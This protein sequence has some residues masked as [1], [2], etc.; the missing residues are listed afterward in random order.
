M[1]KERKL[2]HDHK[3]YT[4]T[5]RGKVV[6][7]MLTDSSL[8]EA[9]QKANPGA[10]TLIVNTIETLEKSVRVTYKGKT[11]GKKQNGKDYFPHNGANTLVVYS[12]T[13]GRKIAT[14]VV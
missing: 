9:F 1:A 2:D 8:K 5:R 13:S 14:A 10:K 4:I 6:A 3:V 12:P 11:A 7:G